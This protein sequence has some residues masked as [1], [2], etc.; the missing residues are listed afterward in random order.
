MNFV[1][2]SAVAELFLYINIYDYKRVYG[3]VDFI[4]LSI[5]LLQSLGKSE[6][7]KLSSRTSLA[8]LF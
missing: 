5:F 6:L 8:D 3:S 2:T 4:L 1:T 7:S